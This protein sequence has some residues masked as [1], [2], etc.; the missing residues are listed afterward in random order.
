FGKVYKG[1]IDNGTTIVA[2]KQLDTES[3]QGVKE[4]WTEVKMLSK[5]QHTHLVA[6]IGQCNDCQEM[7]L[8]YEYVACAN[9][10]YKTS[11]KESGITTSSLT[12]EQ[13]LNICIGV[14]R[15]LDYLH[16]GTDQ[17]FIH[18]DVK[19]TNIL[20]DEN[21][22]AKIIDFGL[23][24]GLTSH[25]TIHMRR[26]VKGTLGYF[27]P[28]YFL[29]HKLTKKSDVYAFGVVLFEILSRRPLVDIKLE[30]DQA[31]LILCSQECIKKGKPD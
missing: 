23:S 26:K 21:W 13:R 3:Q 28:D 18:Q 31:S 17:G 27:D 20:L 1:F 9:C 19:T 25:S 15:K 22:V 29:R 2:I 7:I 30:E 24:K 12:W 10:I 5:L 16:T 11:R 14:A 6:L 8:V 4:F